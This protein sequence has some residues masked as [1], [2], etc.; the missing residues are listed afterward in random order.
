[1]VSNIGFLPYGVQCGALNWI[2][3]F[4]DEPC[5]PNQAKHFGI[6]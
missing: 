1:M 5:L 4:G 6:A 2:G 3:V